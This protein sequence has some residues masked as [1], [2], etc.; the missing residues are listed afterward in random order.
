MDFMRD[1]IA[2]LGLFSITGAAIDRFMLKREKAGLLER[3]ATW[4]I[5]ISYIKVPHLHRTMAEKSL[6]LVKVLLGSKFFSFR[7]I[8]TVS[9][10]SVGLTLFS[11]FLG[12]WIGII[13][14][15]EI[16][17]PF[18]VIV[19][20]WLLDLT[21]SNEVILVFLIF[22]PL[23]NLILDGLTCFITFF[24]LRKI[25]RTNGLMA[26]IYVLV[27]TLAAILTG[28]ICLYTGAWLY[29]LTG[30]SVAV[31]GKL[32]RATTMGR[33][34]AIM[35]FSM[36]TAIPTVLYMCVMFLLVLCKT[37]LSSSKFIA[38]SFLERAMDPG[39][40]KFAPFTLF[41]IS[42]GVLAAFIRT[43]VQVLS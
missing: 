6:A 28:F 11:L 2:V 21:S 38:A 9:T 10:I 23:L 20:D 37:V 8:I 14:E 4:W 33:G 29:E 16:Y 12:Y 5:Q 13:R 25:Q 24:L 26:I 22:F 30:E 1:V 15:L 34:F 41:G 31:L 32:N 42:C 39:V 18:Y 3:M 27:D 7:S 40:E 17:L 43:V 36:T 19:S 35:L